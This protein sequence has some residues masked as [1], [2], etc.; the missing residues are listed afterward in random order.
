MRDRFSE[1]YRSTFP[2]V[3]RYC[4]RRISPDQAEDIVAEVYVIAWRRRDRFLAADEP[5]AWLYATAFRVVSAQYRRNRRQR[6]LAGR[7][8]A[9][10]PRLIRPPDSAVAMADEVG[11]VFEALSGLSL[12]D[13]E[14]IALAAFEELS[15]VQIAVATGRTE[16]A[17]RT[18]LYRA[19]QRLRASY[20]ELGGDR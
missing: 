14:I 18:A 4:R 9:S 11:R 15:I 16:A 5:I 1:L 8:E 19:R 3:D 7:L 2:L 17:A 12:D 13:Q 20:A 10:D 6:L